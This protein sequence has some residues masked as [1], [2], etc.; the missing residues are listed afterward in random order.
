MDNLL[1]INSMSKEHRPQKLPTD[2]PEHYDQGGI[3]PKDFINSH[4]LNFNLGNVVKYVCRAA[5]KGSQEED[6]RKAINYL[7]FE[8]ERIK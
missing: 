6:L 7:H 5:Y 2:T 8:L 4:N 1:K 3:E